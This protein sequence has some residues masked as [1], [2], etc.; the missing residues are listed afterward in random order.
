VEINELPKITHS[1]ALE[2]NTRVLVGDVWNMYSAIMS[3]I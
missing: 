1:P 3:K 2:R